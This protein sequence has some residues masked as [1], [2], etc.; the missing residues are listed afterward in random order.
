VSEHA[1]RAHLS[2]GLRRVVGRP[3][4]I[5]QGRRLSLDAFVDRYA[6]VR[7][8]E[9]QPSGETPPA[10]WFLESVAPDRSHAFLRGPV[11]GGV[12]GRVFLAERAV[13]VRRRRQVMT[14]WTVALFDVAGAAQLAYGIACLFRPGPAWRGRVT[15]P[16]EVPRDLV[17]VPTADPAVPERF[18]VAASEGDQSAAIRL[19]DAEFVAW[20]DEQPWRRTGEELVRFELRNG[21]LCV[22][23]KPKA[24]TVEALDAFCGR[25]AH[26]AAH[27]TAAVALL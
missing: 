16:V 1:D 26:V 10:T 22:Y 12:E 18:L 6:A 3:W 20:L 9:Y 23:A 17:E 15:V 4:R 14:G 21:R 25:A 5:S 2:H 13:T 7:G 24:Q 8:L 27:I 11:A 19:F